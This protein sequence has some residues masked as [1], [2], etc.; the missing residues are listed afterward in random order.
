M[1]AQRPAIVLFQP[2]IPGNTG[3]IGRTCVA[4]DID[5]CLIRPYGFALTDKTVRR[6]GLDYWQHVSLFEYDDW[7]D[8]L[9][10]RAPRPDAIF[11]LE[12]FGGRTVYEPDYPPDVHLVFG[13]ETSGLPP[14]VLAGREGNTLR[15]PMRSRHIRSLN[16]ANAATAVAYQAL[17]VALS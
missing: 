8:F 10:K 14:E 11:L 5:L 16:L 12:E 2:E 17:R 9:A 13:R 6:A 1:T 15:L 7:D 4:L 3:T